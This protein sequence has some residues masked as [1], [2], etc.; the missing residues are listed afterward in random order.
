M[1]GKKRK[2]QD[3]R[4]LADRYFSQCDEMNSYYEPKASIV[5]PYTLSGLLCELGM[6]REAF[7]SLSKTREGRRFAD[8]VLMRIEAFIEENAL[9]GRISSSAAA[10]SLKYSFGWNEK[11][12]LQEDETVKICLSD[13]AKKLGE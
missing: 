9:A 13:E 11:E 3:Y 8:Y 10:S 12:K 5:K 1:A 4:E 7:R 2:I 6:S